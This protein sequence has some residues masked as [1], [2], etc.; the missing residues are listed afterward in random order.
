MVRLENMKIVFII[1]TG[2]AVLN[3]LLEHNNVRQK[4][5]CV[6]SD[7]DCDGI[8]KAKLHNV[9]VEILN[10]SS[11]DEFSKLLDE[12]FNFTDIIYISFYTKLLYSKFLNRRQGYVFNCHPSI[13]PACKGLDG[14]GDTLR[15]NSLFIGCT[16]HEIN[17]ELDGG[18]S[19][20]QCALPLDRS[21]KK[22]KNRHK[23]FLMQYY[24]TLQFLK[25]T[26]DGNFRAGKNWKIL[27]PKYKEGIFSPNLDMDFEEFYGIQI[28]L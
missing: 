15:S 25:W 3:K 17:E 8:E 28:E 21:L 1:S 27:S 24:S 22:E 2:G 26:F 14:F 12:Y 16:L 19:V 11:G 5:L 7:R 20:I 9:P 6:V 13:L 18:R 10:A 23:V 4:T